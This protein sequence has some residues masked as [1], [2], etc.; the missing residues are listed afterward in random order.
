MI[1][2]I[3]T[4]DIYDMRNIQNKLK[5]FWNKDSKIYKLISELPKFCNNLEYQVK[6]EFY[7]I[8]EFII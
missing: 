2:F 3:D 5:L 6:E 7:Q 8:Q 1:Q 4:A